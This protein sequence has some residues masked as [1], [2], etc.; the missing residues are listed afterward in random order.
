MKTILTKRVGLAILGLTLIF[1]TGTFAEGTKQFMPASTNFGCIQVNDVGRPFALMTNT[2]PLQRLYFHVSSTTEKVYFGFSRH[3]TSVASSGQ[4]QIKNPS[5]TIV[6]GPTNIPNGGA[7]AIGSYAAAV[8]GPKIGGVPAAGYSP[9]SY[10]PV[11]TGDFYME[12]SSNNNDNYRFEFFDLTVVNASNV[13]IDGRVWS[14][15]WDLNTWDAANGFSGSFYVYTSEGYVSKVNMNDIHAYGFVTSCN[16]TGPQNTGS[17]A[18]DRMSLAGNST[19]PDFKVFLNNPDIT[20]YPSASAPTITDSIKIVGGNIYY[21][22]PAQFTIGVSAPGTMQF[23]ISINGVTGYQA[24][25]SDILVV[26]NVVA[27]MNTINWDGKDAFGNY[28]AAGS[29][30]EISTGFSAGITHLPIY[31]PETHANGFIVDRVRPGSGS[32]P[33][34]WDD[35]NFSGG[36]VNIAGGSGSG[37]SWGTNFG[38]VRTMNT[39]WNGYEVENQNKFTVIVQPPLPIA[40][41]SFHIDVTTEQKPVLSWNTASETN[42]DYFNIQRSGNLPNHFETIGE[43]KAFGNS[44]TE[45]QYSFTDI[46]YTALSNYYRVSAV[47]YDGS[48]VYKSSVLSA[49]LNGVEN[50]F[51][52]YPNPINGGGLTLNFHNT[53]IKTLRVEVVNALLQKVFVKEY[54]FERLSTRNIEVALPELKKGSYFIRLTADDK[55]YIKRFDAL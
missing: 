11:T 55:V 42:I 9:L 22:Q 38:D 8:A 25:T 3:S 17:L 47:D 20:A 46:N 41:T 40:L 34:R 29:T 23:I 18:S 14:Y 12:F 54:S 6:Q 2:D 33:I 30:L 19:R 52:V 37:H 50:L 44:N 24:G 43:V 1:A 45:R 26:S 35:S 49:D 13:P 51:D 36:T 15:A 21:G 4:Y 10:T 5:G 53:S 16:G 31:D 28:P 27:G 32:A 39:W 7:G 48:V